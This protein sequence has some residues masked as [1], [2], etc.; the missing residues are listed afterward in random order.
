MEL[1]VGLGKTS[2]SHTTI[3]NVKALL[4]HDAKGNPRQQQQ[5]LSHHNG[6]VHRYGR[7]TSSERD[8]ARKCT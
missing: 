8:A 5:L 4:S 2:S 3:S 1:T 6:D 7:I